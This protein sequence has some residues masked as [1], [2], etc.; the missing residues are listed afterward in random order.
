MLHT[1]STHDYTFQLQKGAD[2]LRGKNV[3]AKVCKLLDQAFAAAWEKDVKDT[4]PLGI[5]KSLIAWENFLLIWK[6]FG[7][8]FFD[9]YVNVTIE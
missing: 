9:S 7:K 4:T 5:I 2:R 1:G 8:L 6:Y 3:N